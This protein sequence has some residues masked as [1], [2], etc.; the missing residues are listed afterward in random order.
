[1]DCQNCQ[2]HAELENRMKTA[3]E[4]ITE[5]FNRIR[6]LEVFTVK[7]EEIV[8]RIESGIDK[9]DLKIQSLSD[10]FEVFK[11]KPGERWDKFTWLIFASIIGGIMGY[12][13]K[14][15]MGGN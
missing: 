14:C 7:I 6:P 10:K 1:M 8:R 11:S 3:E 13:F 9:M 5:I 15:F 12:L 2:K 4:N